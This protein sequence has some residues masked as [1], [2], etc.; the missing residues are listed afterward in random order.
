MNTGIERRPFKVLRPLKHS[1]AMVIARYAN[2][3]ARVM[4]PA[5]VEPGDL[6]WK[7]LLVAGLC[8]ACAFSF[9]LLSERHLIQRS[10]QTVGS[11]PYSIERVRLER[12]RSAARGTDDKTVLA[13]TEMPGAE[14]PGL[15]PMVDK[16]LKDL[17]GVELRLVGVNAAANTYD[18]TVRTR[19]REFYRQ[20]VRLDEHVPLAKDP[21]RGPELVVARIGQ[22][23]VF[24][25]LSEQMRNGRRRHRRR[26]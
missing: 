6:L 2:R 23:R 3:E 20:D 9:F 5:P 11:L 13:P 8:A 14:T 22:D 7:A 17:D 19:Q 10:G 12:S 26:K 1:T 24:G 21:A 25:Y 15:A 4:L 18:I 16:R